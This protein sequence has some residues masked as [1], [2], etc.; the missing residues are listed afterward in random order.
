M[1]PRPFKTFFIDIFYPVSSPQPP[2]YPSWHHSDLFVA[3]WTSCAI[4]LHSFAH[5]VPPLGCPFSLSV[6]NISCLCLKI[7]LM[8]LLLCP[9]MTSGLHKCHVIN[10]IIISV[11]KY[12]NFNL[13]ACL[14]YYHIS[15]LKART[16]FY[17]TKNPQL[18]AEN[19]ASPW[20]SMWVY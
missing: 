11:T 6:T 7:Q 2:D 20:T 15:F 16:V 13:L 8:P 4:G 14:I 3:P 18:T 17:L 9:S 12:D 10:F 19:L 5:A 1:H